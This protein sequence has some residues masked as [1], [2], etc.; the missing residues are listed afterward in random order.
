MRL[1]SGNTYRITYQG[2]SDPALGAVIIVFDAHSGTK[3]YGKKLGQKM[4]FVA[5][6]KIRSGNQLELEFI[7]N[8][9]AQ[10]VIAVGSNSWVIPNGVQNRYS[11]K[12]DDLGSLCPTCDDLECPAFSHCEQVV[13]D[14]GDPLGSIPYDVCIDDPLTPEE[15]VA[16]DPIHCQPG[17]HCEVVVQYDW[18]GPPSRGPFCISNDD[19]GGRSAYTSGVPTAGGTTEGDGACNG[20]CAFGAHCSDY[21]PSGAHCRQVLDTDSPYWEIL[22]C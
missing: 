14:W 2:E 22:G 11:L 13:I 17:Y 4:S 8:R 7:P 21:C 12:V 6:K 19:S 15:L 1:R 20:V 3:I 5:E 18:D 9:T 10:V 16:C